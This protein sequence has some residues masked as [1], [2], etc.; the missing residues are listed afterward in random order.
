[1]DP[2][3]ALRGYWSIGIRMLER[4]GGISMR[5]ERAWVVQVEVGPY[6]WKGLGRAY[7]QFAWVDNPSILGRHMILGIRH[8]IA[9]GPLPDGQHW[10]TRRVTG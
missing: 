10:S 4:V 8:R 6:G 2:S 3:E 5:L 7:R 1:M 9:R